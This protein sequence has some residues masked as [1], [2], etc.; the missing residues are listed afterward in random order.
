MYNFLTLACTFKEKWNDSPTYF[1]SIFCALLLKYVKHNNCRGS[2][3]TLQYILHVYDRMIHLFQEY[4]AT[5]S[6][7]KFT[8][9][10]SLSHWLISIFVHN[11][12][13]LNNTM[14]IGI[15][16]MPNYTALLML[17]KQWS[18]SLY[19]LK[20]CF[21]GQLNSLNR[22]NNKFVCLSEA[23]RQ[24]Q[25]QWSAH[26]TGVPWYLVNYQ[27]YHNWLTTYLAWL[28]LNQKREQLTIRHSVL[29]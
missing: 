24:F 18:L 19:N 22:S 28:A 14:M 20:K 9:L 13:E 27:F 1:Q 8:D 17:S 23:L 4:V 25:H 11:F 29:D 5:Q 16:T 15:K 10:C 2:N 26:L 7:K 6:W 12:I 21:S 3:F